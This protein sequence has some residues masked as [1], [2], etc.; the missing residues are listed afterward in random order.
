[1]KPQKQRKKPFPKDETEFCI[2]AANAFARDGHSVLVYSPQRNQVE[3]LAREFRHMADQGYLTDVKKPTPES[4]SIALAIGREWL[5][6]EHSAMR[7]LEVGVGAHHGGL[8]RPFQNAQGIDLACSVLIF[9]SLQRYENK[10]W[11]PISPA[12]FGNV[13]G[14]AGRAY[15]D[16]DGLAVLPT[17]NPGDQIARHLLFAKLANQSKGQRLCSGLALLV[18]KIS[19]VLSNLLGTSKEGFLE[20]VVNNRDLWTD[21]RLE[22]K[23]VE[24]DEEDS[25][26][27]LESYLAD[28]DVAILSLIDPLECS[29][30]DLASL[31][32][33]VLKNSLWQRTLAH[34]EEPLR[35]MEQELLRSRSE[36]VWRTTTGTQR[37]A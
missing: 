16:L 24:D 25:R 15:V 5:G 13:V 11:V 3:T 37:K 14:R 6:L 23:L 20:Y 29:V 36:W 35:L 10:E 26:E 33:D 28:L 4:L 30:E 1:M 31:L 2:G 27:S 22:T 18:L 21:S 8:P 34:E 17:F 12:E 7:A 19:Q 9:R 32:D